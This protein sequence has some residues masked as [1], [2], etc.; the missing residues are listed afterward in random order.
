M[1][2]NNR[3]RK[4]NKNNNSKNR[5]KKIYR[6][7]GAKS[8]N[9]NNSAPFYI[10]KIKKNIK[11]FA[12]VDPLTDMEY[13][14][15]YPKLNELKIG[16]KK[17]GLDIRMLEDSV[18]IAP[19]DVLTANDD[20]IVLVQF[21]NKKAGLNKEGKVKYIVKRQKSEI[22]G[23]ITINDNF[24]F[25]VP[26]DK[27]FISDIYIPKKEIFGAKTGDK[28]LVSITKYVKS[29]NENS[30]GK[31]VK[32]VARKDD[33]YMHLKTI[34]AD[35]DIQEDFS[36]DVK[37]E[38]ESMPLEVSEE[39]KKNRVD[40]RN[41]KTYTIDGE[42]AKD[43]DDAIAIEK[44]E[45]YKVW[46]SIADV[47]HYVTE[48]SNLD[49]EALRRGNSIYLIDTVIPMLPFELS[50][51]ICSLN[52][53][54]DRLSLTVE[55]EI[56]GSGKI[57]S[58]NVYK[59]VV[60]V[61]RRMSYNQV[62]DIIDGKVEDEDKNDFKLLERLAK[63]LIKKREK[64]G[65]LSFEI[66][67]VEIKLDDNAKVTDVY[68]KERIFSYR[69]IEQLMLLANEIVARKCFNTIPVI[70][71][72]HENPDPE[73]VVE[74][75]ESLE[76]YGV[77]VNIFPKTK[78][79]IEQDKK[80]REEKEREKRRNNIANGNINPKY[81]K[82]NERRNEEGTNYDNYYVPQ[83]EYARV[84]KELKAKK[85]AQEEKLSNGENILSKENEEYLDYDFAN[86]LLL[87][88]MRQARYSEN[89]LGHFGIA[90]KYYLHFTSPIRRYSDLFTHR[91]L[92]RYLKGE[93]IPYDAIHDKAK[94]VSEYISQTERVAQD[95]EREYNEIMIAEYLSNYI[96]K[97]FDGII[98]SIKDFG[99]FVSIGNGIEGLIRKDNILD[100]TKY[101]MGQ[102][103][104]IIVANV[105]IEEGN[106][107]FL[108]YDQKE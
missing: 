76:E 48:D 63:I 83:S 86:Y 57:I 87:R 62:Q 91:Y 46:I 99:M 70:Y 5:N 28:V 8:N 54:V 82:R 41:I 66:P 103:T 97:T 72:V 51:N 67:E 7:K 21:N 43:L 50:N 71:R 94:K 42:D 49:K 11:K 59:S 15:I 1:S 30:E 55:A 77:K 84:L 89:N 75:N 69:I 80:R 12:F 9:Q 38:A 58:S 101:K 96:G 4:N 93:E 39:D 81:E 92:S 10:G 95:M 47:S 74:I 105:D 100:I 79:M 32:I 107:D 3:N 2:K 17:G 19:Q 18:Y 98:T 35:N 88:S 102:K 45:N 78:E 44:K 25:V 90:S 29:S 22:V 33:I 26:D 104:K 73:R 27:T 61:D 36:E 65:Y 6:F 37:L 53:G 40:L 14:E 34:L 64:E 56:D 52:E 60:R 20:D 13:E 16:K 31:V 108:L 23:T 85:E 68:E 24:A 106:I